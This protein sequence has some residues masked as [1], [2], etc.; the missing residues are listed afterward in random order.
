MLTEKSGEKRERGIPLGKYER[1]ACTAKAIEEA[2]FEGADA[3][4]KYIKQLK[5]KEKEQRIRESIDK[6]LDLRD[7]FLG[8]RQLKKPYQTL[9]YIFKDKDGRNVRYQNRAKAA[10]EYLAAVWK[11]DEM[12]ERDKEWDRK[13]KNKPT[14]T[15]ICKCCDFPY[16]IEEEECIVCGRPII[17]KII[18]E[19]LGYNPDNITNK[20]LKTVIK[21]FKKK[22]AAGPDEVPM[23]IFKEMNDRNL[24]AVLDILNQWWNLEEIPEDQLKARVVLIFK[25]KGS[26]NEISNYRPTSL[27]NSISE[28]FTAIIQRRLSAKIDDRLQK[29]QYGFR[30]QV[31]RARNTYN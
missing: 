8:I 31:H 15:W 25:N 2:D 21:K 23:E 24:E 22:K 3:I 28:I 6:D 11:E 29:T 26:S 16:K 13:A 7:K 30:K 17:D 27:T 20:K 5:P 14:D 1:N 19:D 10:S 4:N 9:P 12:V 18:K